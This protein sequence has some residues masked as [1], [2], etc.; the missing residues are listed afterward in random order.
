MRLAKYLILIILLTACPGPYNF[1][2]DI[3]ATD[4][5]TNVEE[6]NTRLDDYNSDQL[7]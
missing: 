3:A 4:S 7:G 6:L 2:Y 1:D 5:P